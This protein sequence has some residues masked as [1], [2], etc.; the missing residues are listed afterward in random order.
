[1]N[2]NYIVIFLQILGSLALLI[3]GM[4]VMSEA[5]QKMAGSQLRHILG[6]MTTNRF[7]GLITGMFITCAVQSSSATT[8]MT[9]SFVNAGLLTLAQAISVIMGANIGT[10]L[11]AWIM[12]L[13][14]NVDL[15]MAVFPAFFIGIILIYTKRSRYVGDFLFGI[16][17][18]FFSLVLLSN[19]GKALDLAH[20][21]DAISFF[22][23]FDTKSHF[24][25][26]IFLLIGTVITCIVQSSAA[27]MAITIMLCSTGV[28][29]IYLGIALVMGENIGT[30]ATANLAALGANTQARRAAFAHLLFNVFGV[31]WVMLL[32]YPFVGMV[33]RLVGY[34]PEGIGYTVAQRATILPIV[35]AAF[36]TCFNVTNT[37]LLIWFIPQMEKVVCSIIKSKGKGNGDEDEFRLRFIQVGIMKTPEL[38]VLEAQKEVQSFAERMKRMFGMV[39]ELLGERD[40]NKFVKLFSRI[41]KYEGISDNMEIEIANYLNKVSDAHLS[42]DT[43]AKIRAML[44]EISEIESIGDSCYNMARTINRKMAGKEDFTEQQYEH[45][46]QMFEL[47]D[48]ALTQMNLMLTTPH[49]R[50]DFNRS[51]N[52]ENEINNYR[53]QLKSQNIKDVNNNLYTYSISTMYMDLIQECEKLG[54]YVVNVVEA[55][56]GAK[57]QEV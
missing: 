10:T 24:T 21:A 4:K 17:F 44:R 52:I 33:C 29:P 20:N 27:V 28:L 57:Q 14:Y 36:H 18:L 2:G 30:T 42:D 54:D 49:E 40:Q 41:E 43:K 45:I 5:L 26:F 47:T 6:A 19:A 51:F 55:R 16:A 32:F 48:D 15:T 39:T 38:S 31:V 35:L 56:L 13:G 53:N 25:I 1:M 22:S 3:Y 46:H 8:V 11:T 37:A 9:V 23:S 7:T 12:S 50:I 34:D